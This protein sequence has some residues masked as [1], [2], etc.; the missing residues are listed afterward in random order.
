MINNCFLPS[1]GLFCEI[2]S[3]C[4][5]QAGLELTVVAQA[6]LEH[7]ILLLLTFIFWDYRHGSPGSSSQKVLI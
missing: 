5:A 4:V 2:G 1:F 7:N 3:C 6:G